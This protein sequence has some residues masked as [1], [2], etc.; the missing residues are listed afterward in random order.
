MGK[1]MIESNVITRLTSGETYAV[2]I[3]TIELVDN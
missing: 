1:K 3:L 2:N